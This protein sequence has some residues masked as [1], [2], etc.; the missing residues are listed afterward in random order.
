MMVTPAPETDDRAAALALAR[1]L[2][3]GAVDAIAPLR[4]G[5]NARVFRVAAGGERFALKVFPPP[6]ADGRDRLAT[7]VA[8][9]RLMQGAGISTVARV[10]AT[11]PARHGALLSWLDGEPIAAPSDADIDAAAAF[12]AALHALRAS[13]PARA[14]GRSAAEACLSGREVERQIRA[15]L[16]ALNRRVMPSPVPGIHVLRYGKKDVDGRDKPGHDEGEGEAEAALAVFLHAAFAPALAASLARAEQ[17]FAAAGLDFATPLPQ[18]KQSLVPADFG[19]HNCLRG[20]DGRLS[21]LDFE[22]FGWDDPVKLT[23]D[24]LHHPG[25]PL[26]S[27]QAT[28]LRAA[29]LRIYGDD[30]AFAPRLAALDPLFGLRWVLILLNEFLPERWQGRVAAGDAD[31][32]ADAKARQLACAREL[33]ATLAPL[34][35]AAH[36]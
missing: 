13:A 33:L 25:T 31:A 4:G 2:V 32:W 29:A 16:V 1:D 17:A 35:E 18:E 26:G 23:A 15:R 30:C 24:M 20:A 3:G 10:V 22:Y 14:F 12:L 6:A 28:R 27:P 19:F 11:D 34:P 9:L 8:A 5:R 36:G 21:F 7:E